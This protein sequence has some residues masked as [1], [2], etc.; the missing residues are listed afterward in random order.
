MDNKKLFLK[1]QK[2]L[3]KNHMHHDSEAR[4]QERF[5]PYVNSLDF[6]EYLR[7]LLIEEEK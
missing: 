6:E 3:F 5:E 7:V 4:C 1:I 2:W